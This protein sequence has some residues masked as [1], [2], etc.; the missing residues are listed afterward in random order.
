MRH[1]GLELPYQNINAAGEEG[2]KREQRVVLGY[3]CQRFCHKN[4]IM[5]TS[6]AEL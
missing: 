1:G 4:V 6:A 5:M 2:E 3:Q